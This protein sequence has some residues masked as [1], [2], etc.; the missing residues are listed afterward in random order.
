MNVRQFNQSSEP[1]TVAAFAK[2]IIAEIGAMAPDA[3]KD[4]FVHVESGVSME[5]LMELLQSLTT[6]ESRP[7]SDVLRVLQSFLAQRWDRI[8][9][10][11]AIY[12]HHPHSYIN[13]VCLLLARK[14]AVYFDAHPF[15]LLMPTVTNILDFFPDK[16]VDTLRIDEFILRDNDVPI[17]ILDAF[18][19][20]EQSSSAMVSGCDH[21][22][23]SKKLSLSEE[24]L[25]AKHSE[26]ATA[27]YRLL[28]N[29]SSQPAERQAAKQRLIT[30]MQSLPDSFTPQSTYDVTG[31]R[32]LG[33]VIVEHMDNRK[34]LVAMFAHIVPRNEW[35][36][37]MAILSDKDY[38]RV[39]A[40]IDIQ[41]ITS[42][43]T[44]SALEV[45][46]LKL[47]EGALNLL[48][49]SQ[50]RAYTELND[51][52]IR[53]EHVDRKKAALRAYM[54]CLLLAYRRMRAAQPEVTSSVG[55]FTTKFFSAS[56][57]GLL[58]KSEKLGACDAIE[59]ILLEK[60]TLHDVYTALESDELRLHTSAI[61]DGQ[62][63]AYLS[64]IK[65]IIERARSLEDPA[66]RHDWVKTSP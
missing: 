4:V 7:S 42:T 11:D 57:F 12:S 66:R 53:V 63:G 3:S 25:L 16:T 31:K 32:K 60:E 23:G 2:N 61:Q 40:G 33:R 39:M 45:R 15:E 1:Q 46:R 21:V 48:L 52:L 30:F 43:E 20:L 17:S 59:R 13:R 8:R 6:V 51:I 5:R 19:L 47:V 22:A 14:I 56:T 58:N 49:S 38:F 35:R 54:Y 65:G 18:S 37:F 26:A 41:K 44:D 64:V 36:T 50:S 10:T 28:N 34:N 55:R 62:L 29:R 27:Y 24:G 9:K